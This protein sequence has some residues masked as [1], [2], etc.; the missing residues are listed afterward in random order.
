[1]TPSRRVAAVAA[2]AAL[3]TTLGCASAGASRG[4][5]AGESRAITDALLTTRVAGMN[6]VPRD[7]YRVSGVRVSTVSASWAKADVV[8][9]RRFRAT[10]QDAVV[11]AVRLAGTEDWV[12]VDLGSAQV[13][14]GI[15]PKRV[16][17]DLF[18]TRTPCPP[19]SGVG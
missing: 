19:G 10:F 3:I 17:V 15:A 14:C 8:A 5:T 7:R 12:V 4:P 11:V 2:A 18:S 9:R 6:T 16:L 1:M 13:G